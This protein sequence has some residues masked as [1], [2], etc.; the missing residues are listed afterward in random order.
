MASGPGPS[1]ERTISRSSRHNTIQRGNDMRTP[2]L[3]MI[4]ALA[5][6][7]GWS[8]PTPAVAATGAV[9]VRMAAGLRV[10]NLQITKTVSPDPMIIGAESYY[11]ITVTNNGDEPATDVTVTDTLDPNLTAGDLPDGCAISGQTVTCGGPGTTIQPGESVVYRVPVTVDP[12]LADGTNITNPVQATASNAP[13]ASTQLI[14]QT[15][16]MTDVEI[17]KTGTVNDDGTIT[18]TITVTNHGPSDAVDV[19]VED[20]TDGNQTT[21]VDRPGECPGG[22]LT[23][24]C[25]LGTLE[26]DESRTFTFTVT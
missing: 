13:G 8:A 26:P 14:S 15:Q 16:T 21:I 12:S 7:G 10:A 6:L 23:L 9:P 17:V 25:P 19:T 11:T 22:G 20:E 5:A 3:A 2:G 24:T 1:Q 4:V 18:W